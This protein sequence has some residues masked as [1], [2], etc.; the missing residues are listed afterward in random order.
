MNLANR[1][2]V[3]C[4]LQEGLGVHII[5]LISKIINMIALR[6]GDNLYDSLMILFGI[7]LNIFLRNECLL[8]VGFFIFSGFS[9]IFRR[10]G[11][12]E[13]C[14]GGVLVI[15]LTGFLHLLPDLSE[16]HDIWLVVDIFCP[17]GKI[18][19]EKI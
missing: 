3:S 4:S 11:L 19:N 2:G 18:H 6:V 14:F 13:G 10:L 9:F 15:G 8:G 1:V 5:F 16:F 12:S 17:F 7:P